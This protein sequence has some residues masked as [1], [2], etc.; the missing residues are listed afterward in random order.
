[1]ILI[2]PFAAVCLFII[3]FAHTKDFIR[4]TIDA[5]VIF[6]VLTVLCCEI[7]SIF[8]IYK[9][10]WVF[11]FWIVACIAMILCSKQQIIVGKN[12]L[13]HKHFIFL[14]P[15]QKPVKVPG[16]RTVRRKGEPNAPSLP[17]EPHRFG[18]FEKFALG[19]IFLFAIGTLIIGLVYPPTNY[20]SMV[21]HMPRV[22]FWMKNASVH[23]FPTDFSQQLYATPLNSFFILQNQVLFF[24]CDFF[25]NIVQWFSYLGLILAVPGISLKLGSNRKNAIF[26]A[27]ITA[28]TPLAIMQASTTQAD[29]LTTYWCIAVV[30]YLSVFLTEKLSKKD[31]YILI[32]FVGFAVGLAVLAKHTAYLWLAP[33]AA[34]FLVLLL[35]RK[36]WKTLMISGGLVVLCMLTVNSGF[37]VRNALDLRGDFLALGVSDNDQ[38]RARP[39]DIRYAVALAL[40]NLSFNLMGSPTEVFGPNIDPV[41][42]DTVSGI[43]DFMGVDM[44]ARE[45]S[46][47]TF[48]ERMEQSNI[49]SESFRTSPV[50]QLISYLTLC[51]AIVLLIK[52][53][54]RAVG[55]L[56]LTI[57]VVYISTA[58]SL[59]F[60]LS[61]PRY[62][63]FPL[64][65]SLFLIPLVFTKALN[66]LGVIYSVAVVMVYSAVGPLL[67][68]NLQP[69]ISNPTLAVIFNSRNPSF[70]R[71]DATYNQMRSYMCLG[72]EVQPAI[73]ELIAV[74][75]KFE[76]KNI[77]VSSDHT[78]AIY[79]L[80]YPFIGE[81]YNVQF[82]N[83]TY[84]W[85]PASE[86]VP[87]IIIETARS[88]RP[89]FAVKRDNNYLQQPFYYD[90]N[91]DNDYLQQSF[92]YD[93]DYYPLYFGYK[94]ASGFFN[95]YVTE[96]MINYLHQERDWDISTDSELFFGEGGTA[97]QYVHG[98]VHP[99]DGDMTVAS[100]I[101][102]FLFRI[103]TEA[104]ESERFRF[105]LELL[106]IINPRTTFAMIDLHCGEYSK[107]YVL[108][109]EHKTVVSLDI[110]PEA[111]SE[112]G[113]VSLYMHVVNAHIPRRGVE[114]LGAKLYRMSV[115]SSDIVAFGTPLGKTLAFGID[116]EATLLIRDGVHEAEEGLNWASEINYLRIRPDNP[117]RKPFT[118]QMEVVPAINPET[119]QMAVAA[120]CNGVFI[121]RHVLLR[122][123]KVTLSW[124]IPEELV[125]L[126]ELTIRIECRD[127]FKFD[128]PEMDPD[129]I[130]TLGVKL[131]NIS[132]QPVEQSRS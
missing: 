19:V 87:D 17:Q 114:R 61:T 73:N 95:I 28:L 38:T 92:Y 126:E 18:G 35:K 62:M 34:W 65:V 1:M 128:I 4:S 81:Q 45:I 29:I 58:V 27:L 112:T 67:F 57:I 76:V 21:Y 122:E 24:N 75:E 72:R 109:N 132:L 83:S 118:L 14:K 50:H 39:K 107:R 123:D 32:I 55:L 96:N 12:T 10:I 104:D 131:L 120:F 82:V 125:G 7:L 69:I 66:R 101:T 9:D 23:N 49:N 68:A 116:A 93:R 84:H 13:F 97:L 102:H 115:T 90:R 111:I 110:P 46:T 54:N 44:D 103:D 113:H 98:G 86:F 108:T 37:Y 11:S 91:W 121:G 47:R 129:S 77:G 74:A 94:V 6:G 70:S 53:K 60:M 43:S 88:V 5:S 130:R 79:P 80:L 59:R 106:P 85:Q 105:S 16:K 64:I 26:V 15:T 36:E 33:F 127:A 52:K 31:L 20:D 124:D 8:S 51:A 63:L 40:K 3:R 42:Y 99:S 22:F 89:A 117:E 41:I 78:W 25:S 30:Y 2:L 48:R 119:G 56:A 71:F 100:A